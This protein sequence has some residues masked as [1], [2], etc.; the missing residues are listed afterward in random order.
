MHNVMS[1]VQM[2]PANLLNALSG[3][4]YIVSVDHTVIDCGGTAWERF[5]AENAGVP[6]LARKG[7]RGADLWSFIRG[8]ETQDFYKKCMERLDCAGERAV[9]FTFRCD[10]PTVRRETL[11]TISSICRE[12]RLLGYLFH[13][14]TIAETERPRVTL[15]DRDAMLRAYRAESALPTLQVCSLCLRVLTETPEGEHWCEA[16]EY[17]RR[18][19]T[20][21]VRLSH[22]LCPVC[23]E[24]WRG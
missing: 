20:D 7:V 5:A 10:S 17:Y 16:E 24:K 1:P 19:G 8:A 6:G 13:A 3:C 22:G 21:A 12:S 4:A 23:A 14:Q 15:M 11:M 2:S 9:S 18:G